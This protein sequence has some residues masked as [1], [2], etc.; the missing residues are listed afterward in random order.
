MRNDRLSLL[1]QEG[2]TVA[3]G[4]ANEW[5]H[6]LV[7]LAADAYQGAARFAAGRG[8]GGSFADLG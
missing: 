2:Q 6:G 5:Q 7:S 8:R 3:A 4:L 1:E